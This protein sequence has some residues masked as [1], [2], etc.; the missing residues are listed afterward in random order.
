VA[1]FVLLN[2]RLFAGGVDLT[3]VWNRVTLGCELEE[4]PTT[5]FAGKGW[6]SLLGGLFSTSWDAGGQW[7]AGPGLVDDETWAGLV[8]RGRVPWTACPENA[9]VGSLAWFSSAQRSS[10]QLGE[11][12]GEVAPWGAKATGSGPL[13]RGVVAHPPGTPRTGS[14][15][16]TAQELGPL[17]GSQRM[18]GA[19]HVLSVSGAGATITARVESAA[20]EAFTSPTTRATF[21]AASGGAGRGQLADVV[22]PVTDTW[23]RVAWNIAGT[24]PSLLFVAALGV[25]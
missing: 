10:Y 22:G 23:W 5:N 7:E 1:G 6:R 20:D 2:C 18:Y 11:T 12:V 17:V 19:L 3:G 13:L 15:A 16:G 21:T 14:G 24:T 8:G 25:A 4:K 9:D